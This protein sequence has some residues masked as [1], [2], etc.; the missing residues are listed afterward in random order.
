M[1]FFYSQSRGTD[2]GFYGW[3]VVLEWYPE[4]TSPLY[5]RPTSPS[6]HLKMH[7]WW[8]GRAEALANEIRGKMKQRTLWIIPDK[9]FQQVRAGVTSWLYHPDAST[10]E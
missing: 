9:L 4:S 7:P 2:P 5:F 6:D 10:V 3:A 1:V 8:D